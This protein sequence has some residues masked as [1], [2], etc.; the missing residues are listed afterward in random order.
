MGK[1]VFTPELRGTEPQERLYKTFFDT[2]F[3][4]AVSPGGGWLGKAV[5]FSEDGIRWVPY[6]GNP[7]IVG[8]V[9]DVNTVC[10]N[11]EEV[12]DRFALTPVSQWLKKYE[13]TFN[14]FHSFLPRYLAHIKMNVRIG[15]FDRRCVG[16]SYSENFTDW[17]HPQLILA[18]DE[19][20]DELAHKR[21]AAARA[22]LKWD[23]PDDRHAHFYGMDVLPYAGMYLGFLMVFDSAMEMERVGRSNQSGVMHIQLVTS[24]D[25][26]HWERAGDRQPFIPLGSLD[27][28]DCGMIAG[29]HAVV[30]GDTLRLYY[31]AL[32]FPHGDPTRK[33]GRPAASGVCLATSRLD[34][35]ASIGAGAYEGSLITKELSFTGQ[36]LAIN[37]DASGGSVRVEIL[38][39]GRAQTGFSAADCDAF[40]GDD[41]RH[42]VSW[43]GDRNIGDL[44]GKP[45]RLRFTLQS[46]RVYSFQLV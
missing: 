11:P 41:V 40:G 18:P 7:V 13:E 16:M 29:T 20:D 6:E 31:N 1:I 42:V 23:H 32:N 35:F 24:R 46:A 19:L 5:S 26:I 8:A 2:K 30:S 21:I 4:P 33:D 25:L 15:H 44:S 9:G 10:R 38:R 37:A 34:G 3:M 43:K 45:V 36:E 27:D 17:S 28:I 14:F 22:L 39:E 12:L